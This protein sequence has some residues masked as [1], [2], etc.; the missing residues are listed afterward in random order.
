[1]SDQIN[2]TPKGFKLASSEFTAEQLDKPI[3]TYAPAGATEQAVESDPNPEIKQ[4]ESAASSPAENTVVEE[5]EEAKVP[6]SRFLTMHSR[7]I[8]AEKRLREMEAERT[9]QPAEP[10]QE[11]QKTEL[12]D[13]WVEMFGDSDASKKAYTAEQERLSAIEEKAAERAYQRLEGREKEEEARTAEI[14]ESFDQAFEELEILSDK[15]FT[16]DEQ[17]AI[18]DIVEQYSPKDKDGKLLRDFL[19]PLDKAY[20]I[21]SVRTDAKTAEKKA[22][23]S[24]VASLTGARSE[25]SPTGSSTQAWQP[26]QWRNKIP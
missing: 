10:S 19:L 20:E 26:G 9:Y 21:Y 4:E 8:D 7:A 15:Q 16:D 2:I 13:H 14:V 24:Q 12:P 5:V 18:L 11:H 23:R 22:A 17:V 1:M 6:K 25:G 3:G